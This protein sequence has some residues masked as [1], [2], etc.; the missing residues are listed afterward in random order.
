MTT[1]HHSHRS[2][3]TG[4][5]G[6]TLVEVLVVITII[7]ILAGLITVAASS[8]FKSAREFAIQQEMSQ[9]EAA[10]ERFNTDFGFYPP[11]FKEFAALSDDDA[12]D[13]MLMFLSRIAPQNQESARVDRSSPLTRIELWWM[14]VGRPIANNPGSDLV[15]WL[16]GL[17]KNKQFPL[18]NPSTGQPLAAHNFNVNDNQF[19]RQDYFEFEQSRAAVNGLVATY[20][21]SDRMVIPF[22][23]LD[24]NSYLPSDPT[25]TDPANPLA[26]DG[27]Y[28]F[29]GT[30][31]QDVQDAAND[32]S[33][34]RSIYPNPDSFQLISFGLDGIPFGAVDGTEDAPIPNAISMSSVGARGADNFVNFGGEG[35]TK[36]EV[37]VLSSQ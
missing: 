14:Q 10:I 19:E 32:R 15:F 11:S 25:S 23:Y 1:T 22:L 31:A 2:F 37:V 8:A 35:I 3:R 4:I 16:S 17:S 33:V 28:V 7:A 24:A 36:L 18:S 21:Q 29:A 13:R 12:V 20:S 9:M 5:G 30:S 34:F 27:A 6:F 26:I